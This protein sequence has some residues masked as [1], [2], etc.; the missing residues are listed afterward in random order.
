[1][2]LS[3]P[4]VPTVPGLAAASARARPGCPSP[5]SSR[6]RSPNRATRSPPCGSSTS[7][8]ASSAAGPSGSTTS[9]TTSTP[10]T[11]TGCSRAPVVADA[12]LQLQAN[13]MADYRNS[14]GFE[15]EDGR[16]RRHRDH[17]GHQPR[18]S[19]DRAPG[20]SAKPP[21]CRERAA[22]VQPAGPGHVRWLSRIGRIAAL[23]LPRRLAAR[24]SGGPDPEGSVT[25]APRR[26]RPSDH[27]HGDPP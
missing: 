25:R 23:R 6:P 24:V 21:L 12:L 16:V 20:R 15:I 22:R 2:S 1:M 4:D 14:A 7:S 9:S 26:H 11:S 3:V 13:W 27:R 8:L 5:P 10:R 18:R 17:R 19:V